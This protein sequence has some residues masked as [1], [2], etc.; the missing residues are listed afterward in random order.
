MAVVQEAIGATRGEVKVVR[1]IAHRE[2][3]EPSR[4]SA[5]PFHEEAGSLLAPVLF[6]NRPTTEIGV[7]GSRG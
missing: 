6:L 3:K 2:V 4:E 1:E 5:W 7:P